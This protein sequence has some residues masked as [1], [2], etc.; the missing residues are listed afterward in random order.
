MSAKWRRSLAWD[1]KHFPRWAWP[2]KF[3]LRAF[4]SITLAVI[5]LTLISI[6]GVLASIPL[7]LLIVG[8]QWVLTVAA[9]AV[10]ALV[11]F[12]V[13]K[14][15]SKRLGAAFIMGGVLA[16]IGFLTTWDNLSPMS[17][18]AAW[19]PFDALAAEYASIT[20][21]R[22]PSVELTEL[23]FYS[24]WP[25]RLLLGLFVV[26]MVVATVRRIE[27]NFLNIGVLTVH[28]GI[29]L[30]ALGSVYYQGLKKEGDV[31]L[32]ARP[33]PAGFYEPG[34][35]AT[36]FYDNTYLTLYVQQFRNWE[37]RPIS[38]VPRYN[39]RALNVLPEVAGQEQTRTA[40]DLARRPV[41]TAEQVEAQMPLDL[42]VPEST[43]GMVD[44]DI[45]FRLV[46]Y[47]TYAS[48][49]EDWVQAEPPVFGGDEATNPLRIIY[50]TIGESDRPDVSFILLPNRPAQRLSES[51]V[52]GLEF[53]RGMSDER[54]AALAE[55][56]P[57]GA[58]HGLVVEIPAAG[59]REVVAVTEGTEFEVAGH[60][61]NVE[62]LLPQPPFPIITEGYENALSSV[63]IINI[64][65][66]DGESFQ[67]YAY[68]R[69]PEIDQ[70]ILGEA[71]DG[72]PNRRDADPSV[73][74][75]YIDAAR[76]QIYFDEQPDRE[77][78]RSIV[79]LPN[80]EVSVKTDLPL[81]AKLDD[82][83][84]SRAA[85]ASAPGVPAPPLLKVD[86]GHRWEHARRFERPVPT[87]ELEREGRFIGTHDNAFLAVEV[88]ADRPA[89]DPTPGRWS[90]VVW[91]PF[92]RYLGAQQEN[93]REVS[94][95]GGRERTIKLAFG[96]RQH[97]L[98]NF[99]LG[100]EE[101]EMIPYEHGGPPR[102]FRSV[103]KVM[104]FD[105]DLEPFS[106][107]VSL[108]SPLRAPFIENTDAPAPVDFVRSMLIGLR[109]DQLKLSQAGWDATTWRET[110]AQ[111]GQVGSP[112][113]QPYV[114]FTIL[115][116]GNNPGI[117]IIA[118]GGVLIGLGTPWAFY[119]KPTLLK[120]RKERLAAEAKK[121][122][123]AEGTDSASHR[124]RPA[125]AES[126]AR[127]A[128]PV[129]QEDEQPSAAT[130]S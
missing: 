92:T 50:L 83:F 98:A 129:L 77:R 101:F 62:S 70:D 114:M 45:R 105:P 27:F 93:T 82:I 123:Q 112:V 127:E 84:G 61:F 90:T 20:I 4:S 29:V 5:L 7:G 32:H 124:A 2:A 47:A 12:V 75:S 110:E 73:R 109:P 15:M 19:R 118:L 113:E 3:V 116:V 13:V 85:G 36:T 117:S 16:A 104:P 58:S 44:E 108:N 97:P 69:F 128:K 111:M 95:P 102:D 78:I 66:P 57:R 122:Q 55:E 30:I 39:D 38:G 24:A 106:A 42:S 88:S 115:G 48:A 8:L 51:D 37:Q 107:E 99:S 41:L 79:R 130:A 126:V 14:S 100:L 33:T 94:I 1:D 63:A 46:G 125:P 26:N 31:L 68:H 121:A 80:G 119:V 60:A 76:L 34:P 10:P 67:R 28:T 81:Y 74:I 21:R 87:P 91:L 103:V 54:F 86:V 59:V 71:P 120:R 6:Y 17:H 64:T 43:L 49:A 65:T 56:L 52:I 22:L 72:R 35:V 9:V 53:T 89:T 23:E 25:M 96:R 18:E 11:G 40:L